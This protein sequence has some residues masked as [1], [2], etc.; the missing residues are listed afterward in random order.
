[1]KPSILIRPEAEKEIEEAYRWYEKRSIGLGSEFLLCVEEGLENIR[2][3]PDLY[4]VVHRNIKR[5][6]IRK[7]PY[8]IFYFT[9][10]NLIIIV[11]VFHGRRNPAYRRS[12]S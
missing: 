5:L 2:R 4:P 7:F 8:G 12:R 1:M 9:K 11:A 10:Q 3:N 6:L